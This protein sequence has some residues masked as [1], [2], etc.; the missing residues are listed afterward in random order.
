MF[1]IYCKKVSGKGI[2]LVICNIHKMEKMNVPNVIQ[3]K[4][5]LTLRPVL[6]NKKHPVP[7]VDFA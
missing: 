2:S 1:T 3:I 4:C 7:N 6:Y 5:M